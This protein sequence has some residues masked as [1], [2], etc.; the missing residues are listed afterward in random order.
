[1]PITFRFLAPNSDGTVIDIQMKANDLNEAFTRFA[2]ERPKVTREFA[3][4]RG[5]ILCAR[6]LHERK[7]GSRHIRSK[8]IA[9][10]PVE[11]TLANRFACGD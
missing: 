7:P 2:T 5:Q 6:I 3:V 4:W 10:T 1:M 8:M 9:F 11:P